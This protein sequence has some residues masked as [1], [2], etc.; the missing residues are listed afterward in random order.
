LTYNFKGMKEKTNLISGIEALQKIIAMGALFESIN[1]MKRVICIRFSPPNNYYSALFYAC[2]FSS[3]SKIEAFRSIGCSVDEYVMPFNVEHG[4]FVNL[5]SKLEGDEAIAAVIV[6]NPMPNSLKAHLSYI[7]DKKDLDSAKE[8][9][10]LFQ[11]PAI[12][13]AT[14]RILRKFYNDNDVIAIVGFKGIVGRSLYALLQKLT[15]GVIGIELNDDLSQVNKANIIISA[16][17]NRW[18]LS[19]NVIQ[20]N[21]KLGID[22]GFHISNC[23][24]K[25]GLGDISP[26]VYHYFNYITPVPGGTGPLQIALLIERYLKQLTKLNIPETSFSIYRQ[27]NARNGKAI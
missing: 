13:E 2:L 15:N 24:Q 5:L 10:I 23:E 25:E 11:T 18:L 26:L 6:Q 19:E 21:F 1:K 16:T 7:S 4:D 22:I 20:K 17:G 14:Y 12:V 27:I 9:N 3:R 8:R